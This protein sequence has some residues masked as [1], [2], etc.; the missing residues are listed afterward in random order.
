MMADLILVVD[1]N[2]HAADSLGFVLRHWGYRV[3][4]AYDGPSA[5]D[6]ARTRL[7]CAV[8]LDIEMPSMSGFEVA[9]H[10]RGCHAL[11][12]LVVVALSGHDPEDHSSVDFDYHLSKPLHF[13][14]LRRLLSKAVGRSSSS[15]ATPRP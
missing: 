5:L 4:V 7:P 10:L 14:H 13:E 2:R 9:R 15:V 3:L 11:G 6:L 8:I 1:D 12:G